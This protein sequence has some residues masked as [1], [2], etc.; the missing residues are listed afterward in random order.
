MQSNDQMNK[1][2][3]TISSA[4]FILIVS[5]MLAAP[6]LNAAEDVQQTTF[7]EAED[8]VNALISA[9]QKN[10]RDAFL[11]LFGRQYEEVIIGGDKVTARKNL[12][13]AFR[14]MQTHTDLVDDGK[15]RKILFIGS[16]NWPVPFP[17]VREKRRWRFDTEAGIEEMVNR[18]VGRNE[19]DA[20]SVCHAYI[21]AQ[22][23]YASA[24]RDGDEVL[25]YAQ[26]ITST[27]GHKDGLYWEAGPGEEI[28]PFGPFMAD[29]KG[30]L[31]GR[32]P[33]DPFK[34]YYYK[35][36]TRQGANA[37]GG[38]YDYIINGDM[39]AGFALIAFPADYGNSGVMTF[40]C[41]HQGK[42]LE[43]DFG[44]D[45][46]LIAAGIDEYNPGPSWKQVEQ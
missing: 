16:E 42:V 11:D 22:I 46:D 21:D 4:I 39:I 13:I 20:I 25:E 7:K 10:D 40:M 15:N 28:S 19:L 30:Y 36:I 5:L 18:R 24:D 9:L 17:L 32:D 44:P 27:D 26:V 31:E 8:V 45:S 1:N 2:L 34:G 3:N 12:G 6:L 33:G 35:V 38:R 43:M 14:A 41:N 29:A 23:G 37:P